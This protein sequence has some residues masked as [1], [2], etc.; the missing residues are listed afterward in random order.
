MTRRVT[1]ALIGLLGVSPVSAQ[2]SPHLP[3]LPALTP[4]QRARVDSGQAVVITER[5]AESPWPRVTIFRTIA[6]APEEAAAVFA[7]YARN[8]EYLPN[9]L[10][11]RVVRAVDAATREIDYVLS[12][13]IVSDEA[14]TVH[15]R[16]AARDGSQGGG[17][18]F[19]W[20]LVRATSTKVADGDAR[21]EPHAR[22]TLMAYR[23]FVVPG[24]RIAGLGI[25]RARAER[26]VVRTTEAFAA[27][28]LRVRTADRPLL[29]REVAALRA[30]LGRRAG[31][32]RER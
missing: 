10:K 11:S 24:G 2:S 20:R 17:Y 3:P 21:F 12:V 28:V 8:A 7:D 22:G 19:D 29:D 15:T 4:A 9:V 18:D 13:P 27:E 31:D 5:V 1:L 16:V 26:D 23:S 6:S 25:I 32:G 30:M 14:Y